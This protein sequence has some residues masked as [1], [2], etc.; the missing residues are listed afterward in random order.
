LFVY[1]RNRYA[2]VYPQTILLS[3]VINWYFKYIYPLGTIRRPIFIVLIWL[4]RTSGLKNGKTTNDSK[5]QMKATPIAREYMFDWEAKERYFWTRM[6]FLSEWPS[7]CNLNLRLSTLSLCWAITI[8]ASIDLNEILFKLLD[9]R[10]ATQCSVSLI[11]SI[12]RFQFKSDSN[13]GDKLMLSCSVGVT[14]H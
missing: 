14:S 9:Q 5:K 2:F 7:E 1:I 4:N 10:Y 3:V 12:T 8:L 11:L 6:I 13:F